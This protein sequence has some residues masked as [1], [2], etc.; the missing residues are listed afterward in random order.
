MLATMNSHL[1]DSLFCQ[2]LHAGQRPTPVRDIQR[3]IRNAKRR[4][5]ELAQMIDAAVALVE[6]N[7]LYA[8]AGEPT[9]MAF[10]RK[11]CPEGTEGEASGRGSLVSQTATGLGCTCDAWP[12]AKKAGPGDGL[13]CPDILAALLQV[14]L[15]RAFRPL[16]YSPQALW[17][18]ALG[19]L[20]HQMTKAT[21]TSWL[22]GTKAVSEASS[23]RLLTVEVRN[24]YAQ[25]WLTHRLQP[26]INR[27]VAGV[28]GYD[29]DVC[30]VV[31]PM[32]SH[33]LRD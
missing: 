8:M 26:V 27:V 5:P 22:A 19:E 29:L 33:R 24:Q 6:G 9:L 30:F 14:Y 12:P 18:E 17:Q 7:S 15:N 11:A 16:P 23:A 32:R 10:C 2:V 25:E 3:A 1:A 21:F 31:T 28:A 13:Y 20:Q 4:W